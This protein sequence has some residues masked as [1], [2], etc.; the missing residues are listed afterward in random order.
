M[1]AI[2]GVVKFVE[3][4]ALAGVA[5]GVTAL[6]T[7]VLAREAV[8][9]VERRA[10]VT[11]LPFEVFEVV[12]FVTRVGFFT[13]AVCADTIAGTTKLLKITE[14]KSFPITLWNKQTKAQ[15]CY[16]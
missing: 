8:F 10:R 2:V 9:I 13:I 15:N 14:I 3:T 5:T 11:A 6:E 1:F 7:A 12:A 4:A 16:L